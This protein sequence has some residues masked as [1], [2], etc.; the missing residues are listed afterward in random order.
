MTGFTLKMIALFTM[1]L[2]HIKYAVPIT[3]VFITRYFGRISFPIFAFLITEGYIHTKSKV[4]YIIRLVIFAC[5]SQIPFMLFRKLIDPEY[6]WNIL[7]TF[8]F[9]IVGLIIYDFFIKYLK[10][11]V[12]NDLTKCTS[13]NRCYSMFKIIHEILIFTVII[14]S[15][16]CILAFGTYINV[17]YG[18]FGILTVWIFYIFKPSKKF[19]IIM[20][21]EL[22]FIYYFIRSNCIL[23][24]INY[25]SMI[26]TMLPG[27]LIFFYN[28]KEGKKIKYLFYIFYP[29][30]MF[31]LYEISK[32]LL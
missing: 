3:N 5:I 30:H 18:W 11:N 32:I 19:T 1:L 21:E 8:L 24:D 9:A 7:F 23:H 15:F 27:L 4:K 26:F 17:D 14:E 2:D 25:L 12:D 6:T 20:Y 22:V 29:L 31:I 13:S 10:L 28:E 16:I